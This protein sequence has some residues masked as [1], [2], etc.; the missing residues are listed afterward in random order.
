MVAYIKASRLHNER[1]DRRQRKIPRAT[2]EASPLQFLDL[3][4]QR[5]ANVPVP[6]YMQI[7][8]R[9]VNNC[10]GPLLFAGL[11]IV[12]GGTPT[13]DRL[14]PDSEGTVGRRRDQAVVGRTEEHTLHGVLVPLQFNH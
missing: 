12:R 11:N 9:H 14:R 10:S 6:I 8:S 2:K 7:A 1:T 4:P 5:A 3:D 13:T